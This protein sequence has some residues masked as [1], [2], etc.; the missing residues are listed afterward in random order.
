M[1]LRAGIE[2]D[3]PPSAEDARLLAAALGVLRVALAVRGVALVVPVDVAVVRLWW[4]L[5]PR[6]RT[7]S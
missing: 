3:L 6:I 1:Q 5:E 2:K 7:C 4:S